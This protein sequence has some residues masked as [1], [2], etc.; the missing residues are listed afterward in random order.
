MSACCLRQDPEGEG[1]WR[2]QEKQGLTTD[3]ISSRVKIQETKHII[4]KGGRGGP[5]LEQ[6]GM[7]Y[8]SLEQSG[9]RSPSLEQAGMC[10]A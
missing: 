10:N 5:S 9:M 4:P 1:E 7:C 2:M 6:A 8:P 3:A